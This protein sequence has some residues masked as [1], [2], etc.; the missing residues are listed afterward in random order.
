[1]IAARD[2]RL[3]CLDFGDRVDGIQKHLTARYGE[4]RLLPRRDPF[5]ISGRI[6]AYLA[7]DFDALTAIEVD[8]GGTPFQREVWTALRRIPAGRTIAYGDMA[9]AIGRPAAHRAVG[10]ANGS[11]RV[12]IVI[13]CHRM[14]GGD[15]ALTG[16]G[17]GVE[18]KRWLLQHEGASVPQSRRV[19]G[20]RERLARRLA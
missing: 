3:M 17:G 13:P 19:D 18:R 9:R 5:G 16:Y 15:G 10:T 14:V 20:Y 1:V 6:A 7:G 11:N 2:G 12:S 8:P 4:A